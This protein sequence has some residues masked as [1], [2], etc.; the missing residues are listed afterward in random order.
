MSVP[1]LD[2]V[3]T[4]LQ[5]QPAYLASVRRC[6][7]SNN[8]THN[9]VLDALAV[10]TRHGAYFLAEEPTPFVHFGFIATLAA[11]IF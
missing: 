10:R 6:Y 11:A 4:A 1:Q 2:V 8:P 9:D 5:A 3:A 7:V